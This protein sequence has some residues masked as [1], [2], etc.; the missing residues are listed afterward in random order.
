MR[1]GKLGKS[2]C[3]SYYADGRKVLLDIHESREEQMRDGNILE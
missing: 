1:Q 2:S 3:E